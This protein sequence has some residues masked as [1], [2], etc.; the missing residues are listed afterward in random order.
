[1]ADLNQVLQNRYQIV[2]L[3]AEGG[4]GAVYEAR[5]GRLGNT[6]ALKKTYFT[7]KELL[8][9]FHR[10]A[11]ILAGLKHPAL[12][13]VIDHF[14]ENDGQFLVMEW[15][16]GDD[17][18]KLLGRYP[19]PIPQGDVLR[20]ADR[21]L[22]TLEYLHTRQPPIIHRDIKPN[23]LKLDEHGEVILLDFGLA[24]EASLKASQVYRSV[25]G[26]SLNY[27]PLEQIQGSGSDQRSDLYGVG[28]TIY[29]LITGV[30]PIDAVTRATAL[31]EGRPDPLQPAHVANP[32]VSVDVSAVLDQAMAQDR[33]KRQPNAQVMRTQLRLAAEAQTTVEAQ[34]PT[35][36]PARN[37]AVAGRRN[38]FWVW[39]ASSA[40]ILI[41]V[42]A[43]GVYLVTS[44][45]TSIKTKPETLS[46][47]A[48]TIPLTFRELIGRGTETERLYSFI[49]EPGEL[50]ITLDAIGFASVKVEVLDSN[51]SP[52]RF[53]GGRDN[54][55]I[56]P[57]NDLSRKIARLIVEREQPVLLRVVTT[58]PEKLEA[59]RLRIDGPAKL[60]DRRP[61]DPVVSAL[62]EKFKDY[63]N[64]LSL[65]SNPI[66]G[67]PDRKNN[68][69]YRFTAG[70][71]EIKFL[72]D[73]ISSYNAEIRIEVYNEEGTQFTFRDG[74]NRVTA[75]LSR[76]Q[77][78]NVGLLLLGSRQ[79]ILLQIKNR[80]PENIQAYRLQLEGPIQTVQAT[81][82]E[83]TAT[84]A[85]KK[86]FDSR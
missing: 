74:K 85:I 39:I 66:Y 26:Y 58:N 7:G 73:V 42:L 82:E 9:A 2:R 81:G 77:S 14:S 19:G 8:Q 23:N 57:Y 50:K 13:K 65:T 47:Q 52:L 43:S 71:G 21:L 28:A 4:M 44:R 35:D 68:T 63:D 32:A 27:A 36:Q 61:S 30:L 33:G 67:G 70:P 79:P 59:F 80:T 6:V 10:E 1:M 40:L 60:E 62:A 41:L 49:A 12:P 48:E 51:K 64:P 56:S 86:L 31:I 78:Q 3:V 16:P 34:P 17:L 72:L 83:P 46:P 18:G 75:P 45:N 5:D 54:I 25:R 37:V 53:D 76:T 69:Y 20:W 84:D 29:H 15:I 55:R 24:K 11:E 22:Q 38:H